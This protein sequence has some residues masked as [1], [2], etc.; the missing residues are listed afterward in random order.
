VYSG[1]YFGISAE[2]LP[3][4]A[5]L[6]LQIAKEYDNLQYSF[7]T[8][9]FQDYPILYLLATIKFNNYDKSRISSFIGRPKKENDR[10]YDCMLRV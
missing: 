2:I 7:Q 10:N 3:F 6:L 5:A 4:T 8:T 9:C 1:A